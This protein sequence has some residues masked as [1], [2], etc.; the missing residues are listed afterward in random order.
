MTKPHISWKD[1]ITVISLCLMF[2][3]IVINRQQINLMEQE[4]QEQKRYYERLPQISVKIIPYGWGFLI[5]PSE[6]EIKPY[7]L[8]EM[9]Y[10][11]KT[12]QPILISIKNIGFRSVLITSVSLYS[13]DGRIAMLKVFTPPVELEVN[14]VRNF[15]ARLNLTACNSSRVNISACVMT[16]EGIASCDQIAIRIIGE[17]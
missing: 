16:D 3:S 9:L 1:I 4:L 14:Q 5:K 13:N 6:M 7:N 2:F 15:I 11:R 12:I 17:L 10:V 8:T